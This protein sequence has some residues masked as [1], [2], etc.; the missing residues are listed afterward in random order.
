[1]IHKPVVGV[2]SGDLNGIGIETIIKVFSDSRMLE[3]CTPVIF[4][5]NKVINYYK[6]SL[7]D[8]PVN[9]V[10]IKK[11]DS[12]N[13][14]QLNVFSCWEED[15]AIQ[16]GELNETGGKYAI[17]SLEVA[18]QCLYDGEIDTLVTAPI[19]KNNTH[20]ANFKYSG[21]TPFLKDKFGVRDVVMMLYSQDLRV[22]LVTEHIP[23]QKVSSELSI[24]KIV[25][26]CQ[27]LNEGLIRDFA[28]EKPRIAILGL[29]PHAGD[30]GLLGTEEKDII[31]PAI[32]QLQQ[33]KIMA[34][35]PYSADGYFANF[36][37]RKF[38][39]TLAMYH[40]QGLIPF[41]YI[42]GMDG[43]NYTLGLP[44]IRTSPDHG[45]AFDIAGKSIAD[46]SSLRAAVFESLAI[47]ERRTTYQEYSA[48]PLV[49]K[50]IPKER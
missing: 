31:I 12:L 19:H 49:K 38:D 34:F 6:K 4:A 33:M 45:V 39:A 15:V 26:K 11:L 25:Q 35:G 43:V 10:S 1:M 23:L 24:Q 5:S 32:E 40:D 50:D 22:A 41:K 36:S 2:T 14:K 8:F 7:A 18:T 20:T 44:K 46:E 3:F 27:V 28:I 21:H 47:L 30:Q 29:N 17:R 13:P 48:N 42:A 9:Y 37:Y 16:P